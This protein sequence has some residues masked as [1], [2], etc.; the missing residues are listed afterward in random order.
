MPRLVLTI[1]PETNRPINFAVPADT[2]SSVYF[3]SAVASAE[4]VNGV[5]AET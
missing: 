2:A 4:N 3:A 1:V 5:C